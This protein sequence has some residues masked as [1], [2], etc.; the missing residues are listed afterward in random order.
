MEKDPKPD[1]IPSPTDVRGR[2]HEQMA[3]P[4]PDDVFNTSAGTLATGPHDV[5]NT[6]NWSTKNRFLRPAFREFIGT[7]R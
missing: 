1:V 4:H 5:S 6:N 2:H 3:L 7:L